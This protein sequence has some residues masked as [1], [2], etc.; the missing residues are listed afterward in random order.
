MKTIAIFYFSGTGNTEIV[1]DMI[2]EEFTRLHCQITM[3][4]IENVLKVKKKIDLSQYDL[5]GI[6]CPVIGYTVPDIVMKFAKLLPDNTH[7]KVF[8]FRT[9]GGVAPINYNASKRLIRRLKRKNYDVFH[10]RI[11]SISSNWIYR[12]DNEV[13]KQLY[14]AT[15]R[16]VS[17]LCNQVMN[18]ESRILKTKIRLRIK[19]EMI[20]LAVSKVIWL[21]GKDLRV[22][23][24]CTRCGLCI[25]NCP[26]GNVFLRREK[27]RFGHT[28]NSCMRCVYSCPRGAIHYR[29][30]T[31]FPVKGG[32]HIEKILKQP[33]MHDEAHAMKEPPFFKEYIANDEL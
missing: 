25:N 23:N 20:N 6:G 24:T 1:A 29:F 19:M 10:E 13:I 32:Y 28:C 27:I 11:F 8:I 5:V 33:Q 7:K 9:A 14:E 30:L 15:K 2:K 18:G 4:R 16:K 21:I 3:L 12:F 31:F 26:V 22:H 17:L